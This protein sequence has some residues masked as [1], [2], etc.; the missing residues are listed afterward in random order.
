L[1]ETLSRSGYRTLGADHPPLLFQ[2]PHYVD[3]FEQCRLQFASDLVALVY[4]IG[5]T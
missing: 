5:G 4:A 2:S 3:Q 1:E